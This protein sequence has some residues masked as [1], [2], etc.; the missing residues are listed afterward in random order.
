MS[1]IYMQTTN[2]IQLETSSDMEFHT[3]HICKLD[4]P[5]HRHHWGWLNHYLPC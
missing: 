5:E 3:T 1:M 4:G 2:T